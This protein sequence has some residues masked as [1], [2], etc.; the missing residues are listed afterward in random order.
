LFFVLYFLEL[1]LVPVLY[2]YSS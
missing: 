1:P 2:L